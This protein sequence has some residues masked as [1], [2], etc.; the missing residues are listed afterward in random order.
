MAAQPLP[1]TQALQ[2]LARLEAERIAIQVA[3]RA[4]HQPPQLRKLAGFESITLVFTD[5]GRD[6]AS[7]VGTGTWR[8]LPSP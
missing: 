6:D 5:L 3:A 4:Q 1:Q 2:L 7:V 8:P